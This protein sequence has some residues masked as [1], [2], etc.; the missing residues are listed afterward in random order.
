MTTPPSIDAFLDATRRALTG[1]TPRPALRTLLEELAQ[2]LAG[3]ERPW[4][5]HDADEVLLASSPEMTVYHITLSPRIHYPPHDHRMPA[6]IALYRGS[7]TSFSYRR[8]GPALE[9]VRRHD[10]AAPCIAELPEDVIHSV[11]NMGTAR[12]AAIHVYF[13]DLKTVARSI[14]D[15]DLQQERPFDNDFYF[16][17]AQRME[18]A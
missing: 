8:I 11:V 4:I 18:G 10:Y 6:M 5:E 15:R 3:Q 16:E 14:W 2:T 12:S 9:R 7:E 17:H 13:G 1:A